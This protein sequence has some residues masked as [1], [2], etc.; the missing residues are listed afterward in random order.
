MPMTAHAVAS[1]PD[2]VDPGAGTGRPVFASM[3]ALAVVLHAILLLTLSFELPR[4]RSDTT[5]SQT[6]EVIVVRGAAT[7]AAKSEEIDA[8]AQVD[9]EGAGAGE[10]RGAAEARLIESVPKPTPPPEDP[11]S[12]T[13]VEIEPESAAAPPAAAPTP[14]P[15]PVD[16]DLSAAVAPQPARIA[17]PSAP[18]EPAAAPLLDAPRKQTVTAAQILASRGAEIAELTARIERKT[19]SYANR[20][21]RK[22]I[23]ASTRAYKYANYLEAWRRKVERIGNLNYPQEA[24]RHKLYGSLIL[25][26]AVRADG[27]LEGTR[28]LRSSGFDV[29]DQA[30]IRIVELAAPFAP[31]PPDIK[32][33][34]DVLDIT[35]TWQFLSNN[36]LGWEK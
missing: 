34:T 7:E 22:S 29:L 36:R 31:F 4:P 19:D 9:Q 15:A 27:S 25:H 12:E 21:R 20:P 30:A 16:E 18:S 1:L 2:A 33:E 26:V 14:P 11:D 10:G 6:L 3:L 23:N 32:A 28:I 5:K 13:A 17:P 24:K 35:R 8:L